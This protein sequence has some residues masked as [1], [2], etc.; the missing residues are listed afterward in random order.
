MDEPRRDPHRTTLPHPPEEALGAAA[1]AV[2]Q[3][4]G[5]WDRQGGATGRVRLPIRAGL[6]FGYLDGELEV[7]GAPE[8]SEVVLK[9]QKATYFLNSTAVAVLL[10]AAL[11]ALLLI[12]WPFFPQL[13]QIAPLG[14]V[15]ALLGWFLVLSRLESRGPDELLDLITDLAEH[16]ELQVDDGEG[17]GGELPRALDPG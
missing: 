15:L 12:L 9:P 4:G 3:W 6:R 8:G 7:R 13:A 16:G 2:E 14:A 11:G 1:E 5:E 10:I 17:S